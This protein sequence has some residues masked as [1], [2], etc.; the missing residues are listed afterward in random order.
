MPHTQRTRAH[1]SAQERTTAPSRHGDTAC[2][3][4][5]EGASKGGIGA[6]GGPRPPTH[7]RA[8]PERRWPVGDT[9]DLAAGPGGHR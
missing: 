4:S 1:K 6:R 2:M 5:R 8:A 9:R 7:G 3:A